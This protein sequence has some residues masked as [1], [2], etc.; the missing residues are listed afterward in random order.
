MIN[1]ARIVVLPIE[2][3]TVRVKSPLASSDAIR[4]Q[5][6]NY[7]ENIVVKQGLCLNVFKVGKHLE[8][9]LEHI[10]SWCLAAVDP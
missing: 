8:N 5:T 1:R 7:L 3:D 10:V 2:V 9:T 4:I 6:W